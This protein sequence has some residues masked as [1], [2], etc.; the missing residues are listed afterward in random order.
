MLGRS[1]AGD[2]DQQTRIGMLYGGWY[3]N[4]DRNNTLLVT[5]TAG[6][7]WTENKMNSRHTGDWSHGKWTNETLFGMLNGKWS[8]RLNGAV[9]ID[10]MLGLEYTDATQEAFT[11]TGW[12][13]RRF[14]KGHL[15]NLSMPVGVGFTHRSEL[16]GREWMTGASVS[17]VPDVYREN[18]GAQAERLLNGYRWEAKGTAPDRNALRVNVNSSLQLNARWKTYAGYE[19]EGRSKATAHRFN[20]GVSYAY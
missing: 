11:E 8:R 9:T 20:A 15:K 13:T 1:F 19:F 5:G 10:V 17:Y 7:G 18:P 4:L 2:I 3:T 12:D 16:K 14:E 6:Y